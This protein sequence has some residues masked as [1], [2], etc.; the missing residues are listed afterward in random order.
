MHLPARG[1]GRRL[2]GH[3]GPAHRGRHAVG[4]L[5]AVPELRPAAGVPATWTTPS[6]GPAH[7]PAGQLQRDPRQRAPGRDVR[8][9]VA[10]AQPAVR[11]HQP[12]AAPSAS[13]AGWNGW[14]PRR[15]RSTRPA[16]WPGARR[17]TWWRSWAGSTACCPTTPAFSTGRRWT[18]L[19]ADDSPVLA[20]APH[21]LG[22][23]GPVPGAGEPDHGAPGMEPG[24]RP[25]GPAGRPR[26]WTCWA[27][28]PPR[29][30]VQDRRRPVLTLLPGAA[31]CLSAHPAPAG[32]AGSAYRARRA[33]AAWAYQ[34]LAT[35]IP[36]EELGPADW[37]E[38]GAL[39]AA[40][41]GAFLA[42]WPPG[43]EAAREDLLGA[44]RAAPR[45][46]QG[47]ALGPAGPGPGGAGAPRTTPG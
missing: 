22:R 2:G 10:A 9:L 36:A 38:L 3:R 46:P 26:P 44:L 11:A 21:L 12:S 18:R 20:L 15:S 7:G 41:P 17:K 33:Q 34:A 4:L 45:L 5:G 16:A 13:P 39:A 6:P 1:P 14:P 32:L 19:S 28:P 40:D 42:A 24:R 43:P 29:I 35:V 8:G 23:P 47:G 30:R 31:H 25:A 27:R 37:E